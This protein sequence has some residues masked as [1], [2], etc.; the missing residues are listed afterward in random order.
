MEVGRWKLNSAILIVSALI[1]SEF[2]VARNSPSAVKI[3]CKETR[4][5]GTMRGRRKSSYVD[6]VLEVWRH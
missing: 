1:G 4:L 5:G 3:T 2:L 6:P